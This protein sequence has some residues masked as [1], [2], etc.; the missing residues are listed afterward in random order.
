[1]NDSNDWHSAPC[2][3]SVESD[4]TVH[5]GK[6]RISEGDALH[7]NPLCLL[8]NASCARTR[9]EVPSQTAYTCHAQHVTTTRNVTRVAYLR[10][11]SPRSSHH[12]GRHTQRM[13]TRSPGMRSAIAEGLFARRTSGGMPTWCALVRNS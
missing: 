6:C 8:A 5:I 9:S 1:I 2:R 13:R 4:A 12:S 3:V 7:A 10:I 11:A